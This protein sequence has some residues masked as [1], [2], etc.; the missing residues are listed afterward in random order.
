MPGEEGGERADAAKKAI[1]DR[2]L[3]A[4]AHAADSRDVENRDTDGKHAPS[5]V[6]K[7]RRDRRII[8][9]AATTTTRVDQRDDAPACARERARALALA[10]SR[11][12]RRHASDVG[13]DEHTV[14]ARA[15]VGEYIDDDDND[16]KAAAIDE[17]AAH[18]RSTRARAALANS[19]IVANLNNQ[20]AKCVKRVGAL[21]EGGAPRRGAVKMGYRG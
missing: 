4:R 5:S 2:N 20:W 1:C 9:A 19:R 14:N 6:A 17:N 10:P 12:Q 18:H 21:I 7:T 13:C 3:S 11:V 15:P 16:D 8:T